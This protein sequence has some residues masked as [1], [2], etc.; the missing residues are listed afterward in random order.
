MSITAAKP[1][2]EPVLAPEPTAEPTAVYVPTRTGLPHL[3]RYVSDMWE[4]RPLIWNLA[5]TDLKSQHYNTVF[6]QV[7]LILDPLLLAAVY[8]LVRT[9]IRPIGSADQR[10]FLIA[11]LVMGVLFFH[12]T[13]NTLVSG[14]KS[15]TGNKALIMNSSLPRAIFPLVSIIEG[16]LKFLP[17]LVVYFG[18]HAFLGQP[19]GR[20]LAFLPLLIALQ[21]IFNLGCALFFAPLTVFFRDTT[22]FLPYITK[23][24]LFSSPIL[25]T[26]SEIPEHLR[27][28][29]QWNPLYPLLGALEQVFQAQ[30]PSAGYVLATAGWAL[31]AF[32]FGA[33][34]FLARERD[35]AARL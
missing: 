18:F 17:T 24:W 6:G 8:L 22:A 3:R 7:W 27:W 30:T 26:V 19:F 20:A 32:V 33:V 10:S 35:F 14:A 31:G 4:R 28:L 15:I 13:N 12:F 25:Y 16:F 29:L 5:R 9:I 2:A 21:T 1:T 34:L 11:H 23:L